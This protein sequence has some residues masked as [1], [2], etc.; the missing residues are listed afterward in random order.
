MNN[1][2]SQ[3]MIWMVDLIIS[4]IN[5]IDSVMY[6]ICI[7][8]VTYNF[9]SNSQNL[10]TKTFYNIKYNIISFI[11]II[12]TVWDFFFFYDIWPNALMTFCIYNDPF[13]P[14]VR[15]TKTHSGQTICSPKSQKM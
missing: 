1:K 11:T 12:V 8:F 2:I 3:P 10:C 7:E 15:H 13:M 4:R 5:L 14:L 6:S 9:K